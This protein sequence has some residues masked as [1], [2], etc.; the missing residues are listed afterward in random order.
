MSTITEEEQKTI[1]KNDNIYSNK[2][3]L[4]NDNINSFDHVEDCLINICKHE[5]SKAKKIALEAHNKGKA[6]CFT[7][8]MEVC[9][10]ISEKLGAEGLT[11]TL[12]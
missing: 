4:F 10:S 1:I 5:K 7:G 11:V 9:E 2:V 12:E 6:I 3:I 8:S